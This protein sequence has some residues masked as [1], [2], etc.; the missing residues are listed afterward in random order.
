PVGSLEGPS[1][2]TPD[3]LA[4]GAVPDGPVL[5]Y[6]FDNYYLGGVIA[7]HLARSG[8]TVTYATPAGHASA[9]TIMTNELPYVHQALERQG[10][11][12]HT[13]SLLTAFDGATGRLENIFT[14]A[15][16]DLEVRSVVIVGLR[17]PNDALFHDLEMRRGDWADAGIRSVTRIGDA[18]AAGAIVHAVY[19]GHEFARGLDAPSVGLYL[20]DLPIAD[21]GPAAAYVE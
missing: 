1:V 14:R 19:S 8:L 15:P 4:A 12:V 10:V 17:L 11:Q 18:L 21:Q 13:M 16:R 3:D 7:E 6:D 9:W 5:V 2:Y 20:R